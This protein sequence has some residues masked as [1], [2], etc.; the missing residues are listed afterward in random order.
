MPE[1]R[2]GWRKKRRAEESNVMA[3]HVH[4][5]DADLEAADAP[6]SPLPT[7]TRYEELDPEPSPTY[8]E[9]AYAEEH[10]YAVTMD[11]PAPKPDEPRP[12]PSLRQVGEEMKANAQWA[13]NL[14]L[15]RTTWAT[16]YSQVLAWMPRSVYGAAVVRQQFTSCFVEPSSLARF[17]SSGWGRS[18]PTPESAAK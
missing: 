13:A 14:L 12:T 1:R 11:P 2:K 4:F 18:R 5:E 9:D 15:S 17:Q 8:E 6:G 10:L 3:T 16:V 7:L